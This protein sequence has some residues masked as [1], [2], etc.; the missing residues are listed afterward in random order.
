MKRLI[1]LICMFMAGF[2][3]LNSSLSAQTNAQSKS[4]NQT[5]KEVMVWILTT[6]GNMKIKLYNETPKHRDN[7][8]KLVKAHYFD[9]LLF[10]RVI[11]NFMIQGGDPDSK[12]AP[13][14][15]MLGNGGP[16]YTIDAEFVPELI[17]LKGA[18]AAART[19]DAVNPKKASSGS[20]FYI[21]EGQKV[22]ES[23]L[24]M[25]GKQRAIPYNSQQREAYKTVGG[26]PFLD[27]AYT[28]FGCVIE[29]IEIIDKIA[30]VATDPNNRPLEDVRIISMEIIKE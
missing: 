16:D 14:G 28:V 20:Q 27:G 26:T 15:K 23:Q 5:E 17:H 22:N 2:S 12:R 8:V 11:Q 30:A 7:F 25:L 10:H 24:D 1:G 9:S 6:A 21:V 18:L 3:T 13:A 4:A 29:G 19:G